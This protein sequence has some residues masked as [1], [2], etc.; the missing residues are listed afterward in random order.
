MVSSVRLRKPSKRSTWRTTCPLRNTK[1]QDVVTAVEV[2]T[3]AVVIVEAAATVVAATEA[4][5]TVE[6][7]AATV[8][9]IA[10]AVAATAAE[11]DVM[12]VADTNSDTLLL[13]RM[14]AICAL[15]LL[16]NHQN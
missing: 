2:D 5:G 13:Q 10:E 9:E 14:G 16:F 7:A 11:T 6:V 4:A 1:T 15:T 12:A 3:V 8:D